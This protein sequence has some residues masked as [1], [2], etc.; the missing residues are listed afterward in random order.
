MNGKEYISRHVKSSN[1]TQTFT[2]H[3]NISQFI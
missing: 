2:L 3:S 1:I